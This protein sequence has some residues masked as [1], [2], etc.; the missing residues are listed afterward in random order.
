VAPFIGR[1]PRSLASATSQPPT[2]QH[3]EFPFNLVSAELLQA[4]LLGEKT[5][6]ELLGHIAKTASRPKALVE[7]ILDAT[8]ERQTLYS[9]VRDEGVGMRNSME[10][11]IETIVVALTPL[12]ENFSN[13][14]IAS[15]FR[16]ALPKVTLYKSAIASAAGTSADDL[17]DKDAKRIIAACPAISAFV[18]V[19]IAYSYSMLES[20]IQR[21]R[22]GK[23]L[24]LTGKDSDFG[25]I[26]HAVYAPYSD[27][28]R[29]D[30]HFGALLKQ[31]PMIRGR[32][33][34]RRSQLLRLIR[35]VAA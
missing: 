26:M 5:D 29:C 7:N 24:V 3:H 4:W 13:S 25:D 35:D 27:V 16:Q 1:G 20:N 31:D 23:S 2:H 15:A 33:F 30:A 14:Q 9:L 6:A 12:L 17:T 19:F 10:K 34:D 18:N 8:D 28:F 22:H 21:L 32:V 11:R